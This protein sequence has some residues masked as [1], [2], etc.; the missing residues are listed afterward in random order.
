[1]TPIKRFLESEEVTKGEVE[2]TRLRWVVI[3]YLIINEML[4]K[5]GYFTP[6]LRCIASL[7]T[8]QILREL[9]Y[10]PQRGHIN[11]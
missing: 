3:N 10:M 11:S 9:H 6:Y 7:N 8:N 5:K 4:Y 2:A 1:M